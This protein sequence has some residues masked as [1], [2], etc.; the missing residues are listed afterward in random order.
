MLHLLFSAGCAALQA[1]FC[2]EG[3]E[4]GSAIHGLLSLELVFYVGLLGG[5]STGWTGSRHG[6]FML[7]TNLIPEYDLL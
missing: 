6:G 1:F 7:G 5:G 2:L 4:T 3:W